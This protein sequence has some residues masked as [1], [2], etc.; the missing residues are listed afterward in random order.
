MT[1]PLFKLHAK[2]STAWITYGEV[3]DI[4][5]CDHADTFMYVINYGLSGTSEAHVPQHL[6]QHF[7]N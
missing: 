7:T 5:W 1:R 6:V 4:Y 2:V 3:T